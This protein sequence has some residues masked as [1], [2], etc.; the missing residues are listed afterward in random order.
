LAVAWPVSDFFVQ[1]TIIQ[2]NISGGGIPKLPIPEAAVGPLGVEG[3]SHAHPQIHG[4]PQQAVLIVTLEGI[5]ELIERGYPLFPGALGEN[6]TT[7]GLDRRDFRIGQ[8]IRAGSA[9]LEITKPRGPCATLDVYGAALKLEIKAKE[10]SSPVWGL[11][12]FYARVLSPGI[13]RPNDI[14]EVVAM[15]A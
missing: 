12:G 6:L 2:V 3:D 7:R 9:M 15:L 11:S 14:I 13:V 1:G 5:Q 10:P 4:G 8:Q